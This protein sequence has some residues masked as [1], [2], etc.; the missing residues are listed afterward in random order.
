M[1]ASA[2]PQFRGRRRSDG[3]A[4][5]RNAPNE[6]RTVEP[7]ALPSSKPATAHG[8]YKCHSGRRTL[9]RIW[10]LVSVP[11]QSSRKRRLQARSAFESMRREMV[12]FCTSYG[13]CCSSTD[14]PRAHGAHTTCDGGEGEGAGA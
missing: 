13:K 5:V 4:H 9:L 11:G 3:G 10:I 2:L 14:G 6:K 7:T 12:S 1:S 8:A